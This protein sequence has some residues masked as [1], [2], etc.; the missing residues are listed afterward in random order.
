M[1]GYADG[2]KDAAPAM[3][4]ALEGIVHFS[5]AVAFRDDPLS[6]ALR[7]WIEAGSAAISK[8]EVQP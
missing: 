2:F 7:E 1:R 3:L 6:K 5:D 8:A 4:E